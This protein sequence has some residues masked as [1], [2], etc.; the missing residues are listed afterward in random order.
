LLKD[1]LVNGGSVTTGDI[2]QKSTQQTASFILNLYSS[3][4]SIS[5][6]SPTNLRDKAHDVDA[7]S[8]SDPE[9]NSGAKS[10][11]IEAYSKKVKEFIYRYPLGFILCK[12]RTLAG[13][14]A[15]LELSEGDIHTAEAKALKLHQPIKILTK[16]FFVLCLLSFSCVGI[17]AIARSQGF[18]QD[19][20]LRVY[21]LFVRLRP[22]EKQLD[23]HILVVEITSQDL[24][25]ESIT[26]DQL[27]SLLSKLQDHSP[28]IIGLDIHRND[29]DQAVKQHLQRENVIATCIIT[30][31]KPTPAQGYAAPPYKNF[32]ES[33]LGFANMHSDEDGVYRRQ[34]LTAPLMS[35]ATCETRFSLSFQIALAYLKKDGIS[36]HT[37]IEN[38]IGLTSN[39]GTSSIILQKLEEL[40]GGYEKQEIPGY[41]ILLNYRPPT[42]TGE[43]FRR[44]S[45][46]DIEGNKFDHN[47]INDKIVLIG[48]R[49]EDQNENPDRGLTPYSFS[50]HPPKLLP[51]VIIHAHGISQIID[52]AHGKRQLLK[53]WSPWVEFL[54]IFTWALTG[55]I[56]VLFFWYRFPMFILVGGITIVLLMI[57]V[58][59]YFQTIWIPFVPSASA[60][61][62][63][64]SVIIC[65]K[66]QKRNWSL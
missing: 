35:G 56:V 22:A 46:A 20:A 38:Q 66:F 50:Q 62:I 65:I 54:W 63:N 53:I 8:S 29:T 45:L 1:I 44:V 23:E 48:Y 10:E 26:N 57:G 52:A 5:D 34:F 15:D 33:R 51:G 61:L 6:N 25:K 16:N 3:P 43:S 47:W 27:K 17:I 37:T 28:R 2:S 36:P 19:Y 41:Q 11:T 39:K 14:R 58:S 49:L 32:P 30:S 21:D 31:G 18:L 9:P 24:T 42:S 4:S 13:L 60:F 55:G 59:W 40:S 7:V 12:R 64:T